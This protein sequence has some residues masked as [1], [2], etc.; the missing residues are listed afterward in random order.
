MKEIGK[1]EGGTAAVRAVDRE[2]RPIEIRIVFG[3]ARIAPLRDLSEIDVSDNVAREVEIF[4]YSRNV[5]HRDYRT[6]DSRKGHYLNLR[7]SELLIRH[8]HVAGASLCLQWLGE[9]PAGADGLI[10]DLHAGMLLLVFAEPARVDPDK[11]GGSCSI[12]ILCAGT[13]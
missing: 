9:F 1:N 8:G 6:K 5:V 11:E 13:L 3:D 4:A 2:D 7:L 12:K 10:V